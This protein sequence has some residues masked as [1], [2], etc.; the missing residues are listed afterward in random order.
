MSDRR[1][2]S[3]L[4]KK[5]FQVRTIS[6]LV[7]AIVLV[8]VF[9]LGYEVMWAF[10]L[11]L[12]LLGEYEMYK[13]TKLSWGPLCWAGY[14]ATIAYYI[15][16]LIYGIC[17]AL[18]LVVAI[19]IIVNLAVFVFYFPR[20]ELMDLFGSVFGVL[21]VGVSLS[22]LY[23]LRIYE[24]YGAYVVWLVVIS[25]WG[26]DT[27][28]YLVGMKLGKTR[29]LPE[30]S[31]NKTLEG[32][33]GGIIGAMIIAIIYAI[34]VS[35]WTSGIKLSFVIFPLMVMFGSAAGEIGDLAASA[36]K[37]K[38]HIKDFSNLIPG[39]GG[40]L[41]RFDSMIMVAPIIYIITLWFKIM[42]A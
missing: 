36:I 35:K 22:F 39:H 15:V 29:F 5:S 30:L 37:R 14:L 11:G 2:G 32:C 27:C 41:D 3:L 7:I 26:C 16:L 38:A 34:V 1:G 40:I 31:P 10:V 28:A 24:P 19:F 6:G 18:I 21:Y 25:A 13:A 42:P 12:S 33:I 9:V 4:K 20:F 23:L 17:P 8:A